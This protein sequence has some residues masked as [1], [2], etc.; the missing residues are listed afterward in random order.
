[1]RRKFSLAAVILAIPVGGAVAQ[2]AAPTAKQK[3]TMTSVGDGFQF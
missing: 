2:T 1:M 3:I